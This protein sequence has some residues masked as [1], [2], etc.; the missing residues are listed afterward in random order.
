MKPLTLEE[1]RA[2]ED[3]G[4]ITR[5]ITDDPIGR[6]TAG[7][8]ALDAEASATM[9]PNPQPTSSRTGDDK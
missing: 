6:H 8:R 3:A 7:K 4:L 1:Y 2:L 9:T 5:P